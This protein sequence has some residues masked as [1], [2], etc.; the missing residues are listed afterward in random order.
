MLRK[1]Q[2][3]LDERPRHVKRGFDNRVDPGLVGP[4]QQRRKEIRLE[5]M[6]AQAF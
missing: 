4:C 3:F 6:P 2:H 1:W 5:L